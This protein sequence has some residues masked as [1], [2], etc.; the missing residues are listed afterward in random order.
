MIV[1]KRLLK[2]ILRDCRPG[3]PVGPV[4]NEPAVL[5]AFPI[6]KQPQTIAY[7]VFAPVLKDEK[8]RTCCLINDANPGLLNDAKS[9]EVIA[10]PATDNLQKQPLLNDDVNRQLFSYRFSAAMDL[11][12]DFHPYTAAAVLKSGAAMRF[13]FR[14]DISDYFYNIQ[15]SKKNDDPIEASYRY[16]LR[17]LQNSG[18]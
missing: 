13:G 8:I 15:I 4:N 3:K 9:N 16:M 10:L 6:D 7:R 17:L 5:L 12:P 11:S 18:N 2:K 14:S 1:S